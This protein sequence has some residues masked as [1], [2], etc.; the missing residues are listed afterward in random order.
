MWACAIGNAACSSN[1]AHSQ[2]FFSERHQ[3]SLVHDDEGKIW[4]EPFHL[5]FKLITSMAAAKRISAI[6]FA[7][8]AARTEVCSVGESK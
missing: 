1:P 7:G 5:R 4:S 3:N 8:V 2:H 6:G